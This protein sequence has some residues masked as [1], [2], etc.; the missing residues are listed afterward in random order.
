[1][2]EAGSLP[3]DRL[4]LLQGLEWLLDGRCDVLNLSIGPE[5]GVYDEA[6][7]LVAMLRRF[8]ERGIPVVVAAGNDGP[9]PDT[10]QLLA[11]PPF[12]ITVG[13]YDLER[14]RVF[15]DSSRGA[16]GSGK[17]DLVADGRSTLDRDTI[18]TSFA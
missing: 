10:L 14:E 2:T 5:Y 9:G 11:R 1:M 12:V 3:S 6:D 18:G 4:H 13:S 8:V 15:E 16:R 7:P 17:P